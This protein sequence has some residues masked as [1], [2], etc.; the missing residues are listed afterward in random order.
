MPTYVAEIFGKDGEWLDQLSALGEVDIREEVR[1]WIAYSPY[2]ENE[3]SVEY[4][5]ETV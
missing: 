4:W 2:E 1:I 5:E 3:I